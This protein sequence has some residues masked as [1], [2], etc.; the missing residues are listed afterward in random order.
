MKGM[1]RNMI[2]LVDVGPDNWRIKLDVAA[3]QREFVANQTVLLARAYAYREQRSRAFY[4]Y[5]DETPV[6]MGLYYALPA[7]EAYDLS[8]MFIDFR[9]QGRG[10]G[11][12]ALRQ[13]LDAMKADGA[14]H[15][16]VLCYIDGND[17]AKHLYSSSGFV[18]TD[19]D[20]DEIIME[21]C[22]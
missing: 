9:Y 6:G 10:Y 16:V 7:M 19:R 8:Q 2:K 20:G 13:I 22:F 21:L 3:H 1:G 17:V 15:K 14:Y 12:E 18:E 11:K 4:F 5:D